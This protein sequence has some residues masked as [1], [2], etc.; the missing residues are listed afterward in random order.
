MK[1]IA[2]LSRSYANMSGGV[3]KISLKLAKELSEQNFR[4]IVISLDGQADKAFF[5][6][7]LNVEWYKLGIGNPN[8]RSFFINRLRRVIKIRKILLSQKIDL[9]IGF[10]IGS[11]A[12]L[13]VATFFTSV[14][15][16]AAERNAPTLFSFI[17][18][19][20]V[21]R[22]G[23]NLLLK[24]ADC[25]TIQ[26]EDFRKYYPRALQKKI[27]ITPN[28]AVKTQT[29]NLAGLNVKRKFRLL[30]IGRY[31]FQ[32][33]VEVLIQAVQL[34][35]FPFQLTLVG[36]GLKAKFKEQTDVLDLDITFCE[37]IQNLSPIFLDNDALILPS[38]WEG[39]PNVVAESLCHGTPVV[40]FRNCAGLPQLITDNVNGFL[41][42]GDDANALAIAISKVKDLKLERFK[43]IES[44]TKLSDEDF[45]NAWVIAIN[46][47]LSTSES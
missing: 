9:T 28:P 15:C 44:F 11:F 19:G 2:I 38:R 32:K 10:Q 46:Y 30:F 34:L 40:G 5:D 25:V 23:S 27:F 31:S 29:L 37:P 8:T 14:K 17:R 12:L 18:N 39:S 36:M 26:F 4:V 33:N 43:V 45:I 6:W 1:S 13:R 41:A 47:T 21:K 7:P 35:S 42:E 20:R 22:L 3:E 16:I 24:S